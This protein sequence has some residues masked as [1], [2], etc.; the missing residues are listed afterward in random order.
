MENLAHI[1]AALESIADIKSDAILK[2]AI[3]ERQVF[4]P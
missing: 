3:T 1:W 2:D 4:I